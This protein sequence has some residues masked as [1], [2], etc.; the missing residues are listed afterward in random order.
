MITVEDS[1]AVD[2]WGS[3][4]A[5]VEWAAD[6]VA[7]AVTARGSAEDARLQLII[8]RPGSRSWSDLVSRAEAPDR[9]SPEAFAIATRPSDD[10]TEVL[11]GAADS[12]G[13]TYALRDIADV[14]EH[15]GELAAALAAIRTRY[16][17]PR[18]PTRSITRLY[19]SHRFDSGWLHD[20]SFWDEYLT[21]LATHRFNRFTI[22][23][24]LG[25]DFLIDKRV[26]D[27]DLCF[28]YPFV[29]DVPGHQV[30]VTGLEPQQQ[31]E[32]LAA[33]QYAA[34][35]AAARGI[36]FG[37]GLW[38]H[39]PRLEP[40]VATE[41][42][43]VTGLPDTDHARYCA[44][45]L[46]LLLDEVP[47]IST[48]TFRVH[49]EGGVPEPTHAFWAEMMAAVAEVDREISIDAHAK[50]IN[51][52]LLRALKSADGPLTL[53]T[54]YWGEHMG[55][56]YHQAGIRA[57]EFNGH[58]RAR[59]DSDLAAEGGG[60][61]GAD[62]TRQRSFTRYG[63]ADFARVD[64]GYQLLHR[65]WPGT[66]RVLCTP[67]PVTAAG[68]AR[69]AT[70]AGSRGVE[71]FDALTF[72][73]KKDSAENPLP[74][75]PIRER[76]LYGDERIELDGVETWRKYA[77]WFRVSGRAAYNPDSDSSGWL[78]WYQSRF[79]D[80]AVDVQAASANAGRILPLI[81]VAHA[82]SVA[83]NIYW[84]EM[85]T[86][87]P[88]IEFEPQ[89]D[90]PFADRGWHLDPTFDMDPPY[91]FGHV[92][93][94]DPELFA[95]PE[96]YA[97]ALLE[98]AVLPRHTP[99]EVAA[100]LDQLA[101]SA[102]SHI[103]KARSAADVSSDPAELERL[104][105]DAEIAA[106]LGESFADKLRAAVSW[107]LHRRTA[108]ADDLED[109]LRHYQAARDHWRDLSAAA[110][111]YRDD[112][113]FGQ[114]PY[115]RG[116]WRDRLPAIEEDLAGIAA[117][118]NTC[119]CST[120]QQAARPWVSLPAAIDHQPPNGCVAGRPVRLAATVS[121]PR[122]RLVLRY[123]E[124]DQSQSW[125]ETAMLPT[126]G[127]TQERSA[128]IP[129]SAVT[130]RYQLQYRLIAQ[131]PADEDNPAAVGLAPGL[132]PPRLDRRPYYVLSPRPGD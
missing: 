1:A 76:G 85:E 118:G 33:I 126:P 23:F 51:D 96:D 40:K 54:K 11:V 48:L 4:W 111:A 24:G 131:L 36:E 88:L 27:N 68:I 16:E 95:S 20:H 65:V 87:L 17:R 32:N 53:S 120:G 84:P 60:R 98:G 75:R 57:R 109:C 62:V 99:I 37:L 59:P 119:D 79:G 110:G 115:Q 18:V 44:D 114:M 42:W 124:V 41:R 49:F 116:H 130:G 64:A 122:I 83:G 73:G 8:C 78:R 28:L 52:D 72:L 104:M 82:P 103:E 92:S 3:G 128:E 77:P 107:A 13:L 25:Y 2:T 61:S 35:A 38:N 100:W 113:P 31:K 117:H 112:L 26:V 14:I 34:R 105:I 69:N 132:D 63:Y 22:A 71:W 56:P 106:G 7:D 46:K 15:T 129:G 6:T 30:S 127:N 43:L 125:S 9:F 74:G 93:P 81:T 89:A 121:D 90:N 67:D 29:L 58:R 108:S 97:A 55:L 86:P 102:R 91:S 123:R 39:A 12:R 47:E 80:A 10:G 5:P 19:A 70:F 45:A 94:L 66:Q 101:S 50:G 21:E